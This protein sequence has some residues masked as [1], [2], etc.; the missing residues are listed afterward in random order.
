MGIIK[1]T[2]PQYHDYLST[3]PIKRHL[4]ELQRARIARW[5][6]NLDLFVLRMRASGDQTFS[7]AVRCFGC[8]RRRYAACQYSR[9]CFVD[10]GRPCCS[11]LSAQIELRQLRRKILRANGPKG[12]SRC[13][14]L[15]RSFCLGRIR[16]HQ[17]TA[18]TMAAMHGRCVLTPTKVK[19]SRNNAHSEKNK[20]CLP[21][22]RS[23]VNTRRFS[24]AREAIRVV[25]QAFGQ[26]RC[27]LWVGH[28]ID[29]NE[30]GVGTL[31]VHP[32]YIVQRP[33]IGLF[34]TVQLYS[35]PSALFCRSSIS[36]ACAF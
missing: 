21:T 14:D 8:G 15:T 34:P 32:T 1:P 23:G 16:R 12:L 4:P 29:A 11:S 18:P 24:V 35:T 6:G 33:E 26:G 17:T 2:P 27:G 3:S 22:S 9:W 13:L 36:A 28:G 30:V 10:D 25:A 5:Q 31:I 20:S 19:K 7:N